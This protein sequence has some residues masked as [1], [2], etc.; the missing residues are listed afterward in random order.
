MLYGYQ[1]RNGE[2][3]VVEEEAIL[4]RRVFSLYHTH[5]IP[6]PISPK[7]GGLP[8]DGSN[9]AGAWDRSHL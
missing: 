9:A 6:L 4:V 8:G 1:I 5:Q 2:I 7:Y 3:A